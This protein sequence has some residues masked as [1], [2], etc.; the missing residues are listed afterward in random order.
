[1]D[2]SSDTIQ[3]GHKVEQ[4]EVITFTNPLNAVLHHTLP[5]LCIHCNVTELELRYLVGMHMQGHEASNFFQLLK[6]CGKLYC[7]QQPGTAP[8]E[9]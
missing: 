4:T 5:W 9:V 1:M 6:P 2:T 8:Q 3:E 7:Y